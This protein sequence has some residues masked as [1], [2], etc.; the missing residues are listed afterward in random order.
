MLTK[1]DKKCTEAVGKLQK[2]GG[3]SDV[4][5]QAQVGLLLRNDAHQFRANGVRASL[6][7]RF[8]RQVSHF[9][10]IT[11]ICCENNVL[12]TFN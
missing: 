4:G 1:R 9:P 10:A 6:R 11:R 8:E 7:A 5:A 3:R 2:F 12:L